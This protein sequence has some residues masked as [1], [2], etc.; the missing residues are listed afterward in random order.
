MTASPQPG[1][2]DEREAEVVRQWML[3]RSAVPEGR[4]PA[5]ECWYTLPLLDGLIVKHSRSGTVSSC[6]GSGHPPYDAAAAAGQTGG[7]DNA[8]RT[9]YDRTG[10]TRTDQPSAGEEADGPTEH[11]VVGTCDW[12]GCNGD[13]VALRRD[14]RDGRWLSVCTRHRT[15]ASVAVELV[16]GSDQR[17]F[18]DEE[19]RDLQAELD[20]LERTDP[21]VAAAAASYDRMVER[22]TGR[23]LPPRQ[24][25]PSAGQDTGQMRDESREFCE[26]LIGPATLCGEPVMDDDDRCAEHRVRFLASLARQLIAERDD[27]RRELDQARAQVQRVR[28]LAA[29]YESIADNAA[30]PSVRTDAR[31]VAGRIAAALGPT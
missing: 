23:T 20:E 13:T 30:S 14:S 26:L 8:G 22:V 16:M 4:C 6:E 10:Q 2:Q 24:P 27:L 19:L 28:E 21:D 5:T 15:K 31:H 7:Q 1:N 3:N 29:Q 25:A 12:G 11:D 17:E 18:T 9:F